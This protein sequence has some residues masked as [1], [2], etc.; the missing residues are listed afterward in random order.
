MC[1]ISVHLTSNPLH[2]LYTIC[3]QLIRK[4]LPTRQKVN[5]FYLKYLHIWKLQVRNTWL[6]GKIK[7]PACTTKVG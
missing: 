6:N 3:K 4:S 7:L 5:C 1:N 2:S